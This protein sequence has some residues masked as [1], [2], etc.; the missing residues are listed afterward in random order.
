MSNMLELTL[1][2]GTWL[3]Q[4]SVYTDVLLA[5]ILILVVLELVGWVK[6]GAD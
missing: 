2:A 4:Q 6:G 3:F 5:G 1:Q